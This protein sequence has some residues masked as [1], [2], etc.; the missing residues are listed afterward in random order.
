MGI[1]RS[2]LLTA[3]GFAHG[4]QERTSPDADLLSMLG[5]D[6]VMQVNQVHGAKCVEAIEAS[7]AVP[8]DGIVARASEGRVRAVGVRVADCVPVLLGDRVTGDVAAIHAGWRGIVLGVL[9][10]G[11]ER[12]QRDPLVN[13]STALRHSRRHVVAAIGPCIGGCCFEVGEDV[14]DAIERA[15]ASSA[16]VGRSRGKAWVDLRVAARAQLLALGIA[17]DAI[18]D[19][20]GCTRHEPARF[21]SFRRD[22]AN[23][24]RML[25]AIAC[26]LSFVPRP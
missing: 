3:A 6:A 26:T 13:D 24:G 12:L 10:S 23:S 16:V 22:G 2:K 15:S 4:F 11:T 1:L 5:A 18:E 20:T 21:H 8:A 14:A 19:V 17:G 9:Q 25:A 7:A